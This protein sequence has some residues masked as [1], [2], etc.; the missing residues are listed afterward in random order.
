MKNFKISFN[1]AQENEV[2]SVIKQF[3]DLQEVIKYAN[4]I[5]ATTSDDCIHF[6]I[7]EF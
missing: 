3:Y 7:Y 4:L 2:Y 6:T 5:L 1:N